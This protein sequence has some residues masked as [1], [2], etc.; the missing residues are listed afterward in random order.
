MVVSNGDVTNTY[1]KLIKP[2]HR[3]KWTDKRLEKMNFAMSLFVA[4]F[5]TDRTYPDLPHHSIVLGPRYHGLLGDIFDK[6]IVA[7]D[8]SLYLHAPTRTDPSLAPPGCEAFYVLS[9]VPH[10]GGGQ[11]WDAI[12]DEYARPDL[13]RARKAAPRPRPPQASGD[14]SG[15]SR[16]RSSRA[17]STPTPGRPS[18]SSRP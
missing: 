3:R 1:R 2:E 12:R 11:D 16:R 4:Y 8:F 13:R 7:E 14:V 6:K 15:R 5:G 18:S 10:L 9:P 17:T